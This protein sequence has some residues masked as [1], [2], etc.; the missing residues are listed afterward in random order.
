MSTSWE[1][2]L[3]LSISTVS[4][5]SN[6]SANSRTAFGLVAPGPYLSTSFCITSS[7][8]LGVSSTAFD[9]VFPDASTSEFFNLFIFSKTC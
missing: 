4:P 2:F 9:I 6:L 3:P 5:F 7:G 1:K 8:V